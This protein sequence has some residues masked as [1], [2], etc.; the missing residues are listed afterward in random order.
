MISA[1]FPPTGGPGVQRSV[2]FAKYLPVFG[3]QPTVWA[4]EPLVGLPQDET[5]LRDIPADVEVHRRPSRQSRPVQPTWLARIASW[6]SEGPT[7]KSDHPDEMIT[8]ARGSLPRVRELI[9]Q[10]G[11]HAIYSTFSPASNHWLALEIK[12]ATGLP[13]VADF[14]DLWTD[15]YR[16]VAADAGQ[17]VADR[18]LEQE[19]LDTA[20]A[21]IG[22]SAKQTD[23]LASHLHSS[24]SKFFT[25]TNGFDPADFQ[26]VQRA[27]T[28]EGPWVIAHVGRLDRWRACDAWFD[29]LRE[30]VKSIDDASGRCVIRIMGHAT[31]AVQE[32]L[33]ATGANCQ[34]RP[35]GLHDE[36]I[37]EM[38]DADALLLLVPDGPNAESVIPAKLFEY[39]AARKPILVVGP[40]GGECEFIV[41]EYAAGRAVG[42]DAA[43]VS[44]GLHK[45]YGDWKANRCAAG[46][47]VD[48]LSVFSRRELTGSL[49]AILD[50]LCPSNRQESGRDNIEKRLGAR[51]SIQFAES[52]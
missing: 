36:A 33:R 16:Y 4:A 42:F 39:L 2:K 37:Q 41:Q 18:A 43:A 32:R 10:R 51:P 5:L 24:R 7:V 23:V 44:G 17:Q 52:T 20:D 38:H 29:G 3:W 9:A 1:A 12:K 26:G 28:N 49:A 50:R 6:A 46:A 19:I 14:R 45:L 31:A 35:Y 22:V 11:I 21:V 8:W 34:F 13:W 15:D 48:R 47:S 27:R 30:F 40:R 25:I